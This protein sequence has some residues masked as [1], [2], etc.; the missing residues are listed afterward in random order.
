M[1]IIV[2]L[3]RVNISTSQGYEYGCGFYESGYS[4]MKEADSKAYDF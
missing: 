2:R 1:Q 4:L 3:D